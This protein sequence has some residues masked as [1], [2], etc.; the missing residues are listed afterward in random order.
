L[1]DEE[2]FRAAAAR[3]AQRIAAEDPDRTAAEALERAA[4]R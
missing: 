2:R 4:Q 3:L 1:L